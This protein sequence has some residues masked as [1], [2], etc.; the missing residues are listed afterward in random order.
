MLLKAPWSKPCDLAFTANY[1]CD[2]A[3][4]CALN[5]DPYLSSTSLEQC[6]IQCQHSTLEKDSNLI[7]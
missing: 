7:V 3:S 2:A 5:N 4:A 1:I 6:V